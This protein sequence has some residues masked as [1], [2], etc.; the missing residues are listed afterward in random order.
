MESHPLRSRVGPFTWLLLQAA[1]VV[2]SILLAFAI[3]AWWAERK[4]ISEKDATLVSIKKEMSRNLEF[5]K[6]QC[7]FR[8]ASLDNVNV[9]LT[10]AAAGHYNN[11]DQTLE[12]RLAGLMWYSDLLLTKGAVESLLTSGQA[13]DIQ[14]LE[15]RE[16]LAE[17]P[18]YVEEMTHYGLRDQALSL[19]LMAPFLS[20]NTN[21]LALDNEGNRQ[22]RPGNNGF[23]ADPTL[24][25]PLSKPA[26]HGQV[27][28]SPDFV[29]VMLQKRWMD[30]DVRTDLCR[31]GSEY[32]NR[33]VRHIDEE[34]QGS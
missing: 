15:L 22:G 1:S 32:L 30:A 8:Q 2:A 23:L 9:L 4:A 28:K 29:G 21:L 13:A 26:E 11:K 34:L 17:Y 3:D 20:R 33:I 19:N 25:I 10:A 14:D 12:R 7:A 5:V 18:T 6:L 16:E 31:R 27:L 24:V